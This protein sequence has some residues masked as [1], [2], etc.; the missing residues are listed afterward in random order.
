MCIVHGYVRVQHTHLEEVPGDGVQKHVS[1]GAILQ[2]RQESAQHARLVAQN[3][4]GEG[5]GEVNI[6]ARGCPQQLLGG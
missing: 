4:G 5:G 2:G 6:N 1:G 3:R